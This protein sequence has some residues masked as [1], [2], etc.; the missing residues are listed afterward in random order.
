MKNVFYYLYL[1]P[2]VY[3]NIIRGNVIIYNTL[4]FKYFEYNKENPEVFQLLK[5]LNV[6]KNSY[7]I[8]ISDH[9]INS[10]DE[11]KLF[12]LNLKKYYFGD[13]VYKN[14]TKP[15][16][17]F[18]S[19]KLRHPIEPLIGNDKFSIGFHLKLILREITIY[20]GNNYNNLDYKLSVS[21]VLFHRL[22]R[23][24]SS[25]R[26]LKLK[27]KLIKE[28]A[29]FPNLELINIICDKNYSSK[30]V[31]IFISELIKNIKRLQI[32][33]YID[34]F[35][36]S[37]NMIFS[38]AEY[39]IYLPS[40]YN[41]SQ[42]ISFILNKYKNCRFIFLA[43]NKSDIRY[44]SD[45]KEKFDNLIKIKAVYNSNLN[46]FKELVFLKKNDLIEQHLTIKQILTNTILNKF[47][48]G[49]LLI[50]ENGDMRSNLFS[51]SGLNFKE[52]T[53]LDQVQY[54]L[55]TNEAW[56]K[57][58]K[59]IPP[60]NKCIYNAICPPISNYEFQL[61]KINLCYIHD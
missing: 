2:Y 4:N 56:N 22:E 21:S 1:E 7:C 27:E 38:G 48:F 47:F 9:L 16:F 42:Q 13:I 43:I 8:S 10:N 31:Q 58:R 33:I 14:K 23:C 6:R 36:K 32:H 11:V 12:I 52:A 28:F 37:F 24:K 35:I 29:E 18:P 5:K 25:L 61:K 60:C 3:L 55:K 59:G 17:A 45:L 57:V 34:D 50:H 51:K 26:I 40:G 15:L 44:Y 30:I 41:N 49:H 19:I 53:L 54:E 39:L 46:F 20:T